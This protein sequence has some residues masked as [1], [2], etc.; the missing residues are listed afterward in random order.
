VKPIAGWPALR[1]RLRRAGTTSWRASREALHSRAG[2]WSLRRRVA[3]TAT[4]V[5]VLFA[6]LTTAIVVSLVSV[7]S[8]GD[9]VVNRWGP[10][11]LSTQ[12]ILTD[13]VDEETGVRGYALSGQTES[14]QPYAMASVQ[15]VKDVQAV[16]ASAGHHADVLSRLKALTSAAQVWQQQTAQPLIELVQAGGPQSTVRLDSLAG[17]AQFDLVRTR[18]AELA[19]A[20]QGQLAHARAARKTA[21]SW[22]F[23][24]LSVGAAL[25]LIAALGVWRGLQRHVLAPVESLASQARA[26]AARRPNARI[27]P[28][29]PP[30]FRAMGRDVEQM[31]R[32]AAAALDEARTAT[33]DLSRSNADLEQF[34]YV[35]SHDL[36][37]PLRKIANFC[38]LLE[39]QYGPQL[40]D[41]ARQYI[42]YAV[43]GAKRMQ[44]LI[45]DLLALS[46]VGRTTDA[47][48]A[49][50]TGA[51]LDQAVANAA[52]SIDATGGGIGHSELPTLP[53]D[54]VLITALFENL[55]AN[56][57]KYRSSAP[58]LIV[59]T[60]V[61]DPHAAAWTFT[62]SDNG[63]GVEPQYADRIFAIF[64]RLHLRAEYEGTGIG[65]A[66]CRKIVE[67]HGGRIWLDTQAASDGATFRFTLPERP[68]REP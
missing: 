59:V 1:A 49:V 62:V 54:P 50:D 55:V 11:L 37:E 53:G 64:Q 61:R 28:R 46:R 42:G 40:D 6:V 25:V 56:S 34:A 31:R 33:D 12:S 14:L 67:F 60:A 9:A 44:A 16:A 10:A 23:A 8:N 29:G 66:L 63:I 32:T 5:A 19:E 24:A 48:V 36:S 43:D 35:A 7:V 65:L 41:T 39:R 13:L 51:A 68:P 52:E 17:K 18:Q 30:E 45:A 3:A 47:F 58:P 38:Q 2:L 20:V 57:I 27:L 15:E 26:V 21:L 22:L 4:G